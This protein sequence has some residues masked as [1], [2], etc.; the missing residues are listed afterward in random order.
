[1]KHT[2]QLK[3]RSGR[4]FAAALI[5]ADAPTRNDLELYEAVRRSGGAYVT[6]YADYSF[7]PV[8]P[9][10]WTKPEGFEANWIGDQP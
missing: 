2:I 7:Q 4:K 10:K 5:R 1:M 8:L 6:A 3:D 9:S